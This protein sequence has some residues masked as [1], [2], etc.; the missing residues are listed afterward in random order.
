MGILY[1]DKITPINEGEAA[2][3]LRE[4]WKKIYGEYPSLDSLALLWA[5]WAL[6]TGRGKAIHWY[7]FGNIKRSSDEDYCMFRCNEIIKGKVVWFDPPHKQTWFRAYPSATE[8]AYDYL[9]FLSKRS[10]YQKA[11]EVLKQGDV[12]GFGHELKVAGYYTA[13]EEQYTKS[14]ASLARE[15]KNKSSVILKW[16]PS[17]SKQTLPEPEQTPPSVEKPTVEKPLEE[18]I[19]IETSNK[20]EV[21]IVKKSFFQVLLEI[22][23]PRIYNCKNVEK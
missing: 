16:Q 20:V 22:F 3:A 2:Y 18:P 13:S 11:W 21:P 14:L 6:E 19:S 15:F 1:K 7:N 8:G 5:Q 9:M 23:F 12:Y 4:S 10:R 17:P